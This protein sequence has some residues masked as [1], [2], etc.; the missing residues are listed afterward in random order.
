MNQLKINFD[1]SALCVPGKVL[2]VV[3]RAS[4][5]DIKILLCLCASPELCLDCGN[6]QE[7]EWL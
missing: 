2:E 7:Q 5:T 6:L 1:T 4:V 3:D